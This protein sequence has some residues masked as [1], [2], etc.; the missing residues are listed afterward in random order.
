MDLDKALYAPER[1]RPNSRMPRSATPAILAVVVA[2]RRRE[3]PEQLPKIPTDTRHPR[4]A[5]TTVWRLK[6]D[7]GASPLARSWRCSVDKGVSGGEGHLVKRRWRA[8]TTHAPSFNV[9]HMEARHPLEARRYYLI[10]SSAS[11][12]TKTSNICTKLNP[13]QQK[14]QEISLA[15]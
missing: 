1:H 5:L 9:S 4:N 6:A 12:P 3:Q 15:Q 13:K 14:N 10:S 11:Y 7:S 8:E 2:P